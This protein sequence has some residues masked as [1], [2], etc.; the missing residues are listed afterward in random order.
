MV[1]PHLDDD[2]TVSLQHVMS[3][4]NQPLL[5]P[6]SRHGLH[7]QVEVIRPTEHILVIRSSETVA[8]IS[9][10]VVEGWVVELAT[11]VNLLLSQSILSLVLLHLTYMLVYC[12]PPMDPYSSSTLLDFLTS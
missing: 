1:E 8:F 6:V 12:L 9:T 2:A 7:V 10:A 11:G 5:L 4:A 3:S